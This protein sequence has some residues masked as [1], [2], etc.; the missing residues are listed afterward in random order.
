MDSVSDAMDLDSGDVEEMTR[1]AQEV[2]ERV[3]RQVSVQVAPR[4]A[5]L[6]DLGVRIS[7]EIAP[8]LAEMG[9]AIGARIAA[10]VVPAIARAFGDSSEAPVRPKKIFPKHRR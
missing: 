7:T 8:R 4:I 5:E 6:Q 1:A 2:S 9:T 10:E 3:T